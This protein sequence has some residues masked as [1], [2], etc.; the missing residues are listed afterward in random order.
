MS[1]HLLICPALPLLLRRFTWELYARRLL[2]LT[3]VYSFWKHVSDLDRSE[4][5]RY[6]EALYCLQFRSL[7]AGVPRAEDM[8][9]SAGEEE[10]LP[11]HFF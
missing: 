2:T 3:T 6:L 10:T 9:G 4:T 5:K 7:V 8:R 11:R 1:A